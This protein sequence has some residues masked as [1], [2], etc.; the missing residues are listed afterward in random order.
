MLN[1]EK[2]ACIVN[3]TIEVSARSNTKQYYLDLGYKSFRNAQNK[4]IF[5]VDIND[6]RLTSHKKIKVKCPVCGKIRETKFYIF[7]NAKTCLCRSCNMKKLG[8]VN[9]L[10]LIGR[11]FNQLTVIKEAEIKNQ[12]SYWVC[13]CTCGDICIVKGTNLMSGNTKSCGCLQKESAKQSMINLQ[14]NK[15]SYIYSDH[16]DEE[17][18]SHFKQL[19]DPYRDSRWRKLRKLFLQINNKCAKCGTTQNLHIH[20]I[21]LAKDF[22]EY[23]YDCKNFIVLCNSCHGKYHSL[24]ANPNKHNLKEWLSD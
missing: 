7:V 9:K 21:K 5:A 3:T 8:G 20:H 23:F 13:Q 2:L 19:D 1:Q 16:T 4:L 24:Y 10:N 15:G 12:A 17:N 11:T 18:F 22:P 14:K 6:L